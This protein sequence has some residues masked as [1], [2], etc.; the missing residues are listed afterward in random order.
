MV[1]N[2]DQQLH[3]HLISDVLWNLVRL[4]H[5]FDQDGSSTSVYYPEFLCVDAVLKAEA[6]LCE[7]EDLVWF[8][9]LKETFLSVSVINGQCFN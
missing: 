4:V 9:E 6:F 8:I 2:Q 7:F 5:R 3:V 1:E